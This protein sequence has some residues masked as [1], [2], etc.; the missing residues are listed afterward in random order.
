MTTRV[1]SSHHWAS[2]QAQ[3]MRG[4]AALTSQLW[5]STACCSMA[6]RCSSPSAPS[7]WRLPPLSSPF[8]SLLASIAVSL[9]LDRTVLV[10][11]S[12]LKLKSCRRQ[13]AVCRGMRVHGP[14]V[15]APAQTCARALFSAKFIVSPVCWALDYGAGS[16]RAVSQLDLP[17]VDSLL[18]QR[19]A[20]CCARRSRADRG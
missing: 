18:E 2:I 4:K 10:L 9:Q 1:C 6:T 19:L 8:F 13:P 11:P 15:R 20:C 3:L 16:Q 12:F 7:W 14:S 17:P 5:I